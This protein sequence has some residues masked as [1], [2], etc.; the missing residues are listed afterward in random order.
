MFDYPFSKQK[1]YFGNGKV[2]AVSTYAGRIVKGVAKCDPSDNFDIEKGKQLAAARCNAKVAAKRVKRAQS[3]LEKA[4]S[5]FSKASSRV[6]TMNDYLTDALR[7]ETIAEAEVKPCGWIYDAGG[8][9]GLL[10]ISGTLITVA[11]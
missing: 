5:E 1:F 10:C 4:I 6:G 7:A 11:R 3:E 2:I 9:C 8:V